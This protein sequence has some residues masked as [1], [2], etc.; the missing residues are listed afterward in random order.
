MPQHVYKLWTW[1]LFDFTNLIY[2]SFV[3]VF[4]ERFLLFQLISQLFRQQN[5]LNKQKQEYE[6]I[7]LN[8]QDNVHCLL[9]QITKRKNGSETEKMDLFRE[10]T[11]KILAVE[12]M[13]TH[14]ERR[15]ETINAKMRKLFTGGSNYSSCSSP[16]TSSSS[17]GSPINRTPESSNEGTTGGHATQIIHASTVLATNA[18]IGKHRHQS[19]RKHTTY[20]N[21]ENTV[22][23]PVKRVS[24]LKNH[25]S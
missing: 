19:S 20:K 24:S 21:A 13:L 3:L 1:H 4:A 16:S 15:L 12:K 17:I 22:K 14:T 25:G 7:R 18:R 5:S 11:D 23:S 6:C 9:S 8:L 2:V 10:T